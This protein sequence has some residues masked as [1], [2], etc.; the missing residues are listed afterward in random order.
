MAQAGIR[1]SETMW[2]IQLWSEIFEVV[3]SLTL[4]L[5]IP[6]KL[7]YFPEPLW[8]D[9]GLEFICV[10][11]YGFELH[12]L[13]WRKRRLLALSWALPL[14]S[15]ASISPYDTSFPTSYLLLTKFL[16]VPRIF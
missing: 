2:Q 13:G 3:Y 15:V 5:W 12:R 14:F 4:A 11:W 10:V 7:L 16:F 9:Y 8:M 6:M 1:F